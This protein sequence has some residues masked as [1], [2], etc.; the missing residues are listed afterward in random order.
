MSKIAFLWYFDKA[1][2]VIDNWRDGLRAAVE[3]LGKDNEVV[4]FLDKQR[5]EV[6]DYDF[7]LFWDDS[8]SEFFSYLDYYPRARK[9]ICLT[10]DP[11]NMNNLRKLDV[12]FCE[13]EPIYNAVR[14]AGIR[15]IRAFGTDTE[16]F[17][18]NPKIKKTLE[19]FYPAT[20]SPWKL[21]SNIAYLGDKLLCVGLVQPDG[22]SELERCVESGVSTITDYVPVSQ[23]RD[24]YLRAKHVIIPAVHGSERTVLEAMSMNILPEV[25]NPANVRTRSYITEYLKSGCKTPREFVLKYYSHWIYAAD[26]EKGIYND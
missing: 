26:L 17:K 2:K 14:Q 1:S 11:H 5:P 15:A 21:Q 24:Y 8:N 23:I 25:T 18:P 7:I 16:Y 22:F 9:G 3:L 6:D 12:V 20:F 4:W 13:S 10:T 19:F